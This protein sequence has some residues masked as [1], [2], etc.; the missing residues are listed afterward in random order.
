VNG[1]FFLWV[2]LLGAA[3]GSFLNVCI[4][5]LPQG[6]SLV[7]PGSHCPHCETPIRFYDNIPL[8]SYLILR[9]R[10]RS[11]RG[12]ISPRYFLVEMLTALLSMAIV[13]NFGL[14]LEAAIYFVFFCALLVIIF[15]DLDTLTIPDLITLP[16]MVAGL[17]ASLVLPSMGIVKSLAGLAAGGGVLFAV[18]IGYQLLR[19]REGIGGGDIKLLAMIGSFL[20][21][22][23][24]I[25][26]LFASS[27][28]GALAGLLLMAR[29]KSGGGTMIPYGPFLSLGAMGYVFWGPML[30]EWYL[31]RLHGPA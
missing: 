3:I 25:F 2:F 14:G 22:Q 9:G 21:M 29:D 23:G 8:L 13:R 6:K 28:V 12:P 7:R 30:V 10:C 24:V 31:F 16:G 1:V 4:L 27:L 5:R 18:A 11:C 20:G 26:T 15:I 19:K 17:A